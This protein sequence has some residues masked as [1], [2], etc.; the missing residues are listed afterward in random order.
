MVGA[1]AFTVAGL[2]LGAVNL[3]LAA[4][5]GGGDADHSSASYG[6]A[7][8]TRR[9]LERRSE[10]G[11][12]LGYGDVRS[13]PFAGSGTVTALPALGAVVERGHMLV[14]ID[15]RPV[16]LL[17][18]ARPLWRPLGPGVTDGADVEQIEAN[19]VAL[20]VDPSG[21]LVVDQRWTTATTRAVKAWQGSL[22][23]DKTGALSPA[24]A[25]VL[26]S[27]VRIAGHPTPVGHTASGAIV[28]VTGTRSVVTVEVTATKRALF[29]VDKPVEVE[30]ADG[31]PVP[32]RVV[33]VGGVARGDEPVAG[34]EPP[35]SGAEAM[36]EVTIAL[37][38]TQTAASIVEGPVIVRVVTSR[39]E[40]V[41]AVPVDALLALAEGGF[42]VEVVEAAGRSRLAGVEL[43]D[44]ADGW[45][46]VTSGDLAEGDDVVVPE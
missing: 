37:D 3:G 39:A 26:P 16:P 38:D 14:E 12:T 5:D 19:L 30:L 29:A 2:T 20:G 4:S 18:G 46:E 45:V 6:T 43:G 21:G 10:M 9:D 25:V 27:P 44:F 7:T 11:G 36:V 42:A 24:D 15:G 40:D 1:G 28:E 23:W 17:L 22:G 8:V 33:T 13:V 35:A 41:L 32:G 34:E 31:T